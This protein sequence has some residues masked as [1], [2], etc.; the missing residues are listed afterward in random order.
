MP[1]FIPEHRKG[2]G[3]MQVSVCLCLLPCVGAGRAGVE[4]GKVSGVDSTAEVGQKPH[5]S[6][7]ASL[8]QTSP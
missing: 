7:Q 6:P 2:Q 4:G 3:G 5:T 1:F 8:S